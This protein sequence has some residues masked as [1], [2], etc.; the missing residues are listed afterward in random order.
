M[1]TQLPLPN[2][3]LYSQGFTQLIT[4][5]HYIKFPTVNS[6]SHKD[7]CIKKH[8]QP[9][10]AFHRLAEIHGLPDGSYQNPVTGPLL[11]RRLA[12]SSCPPSGFWVETQKLT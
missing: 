9:R 2:K 7:S 1:I 4:F 5:C 11:M 8:K 12:A 3:L 6:R 10:I